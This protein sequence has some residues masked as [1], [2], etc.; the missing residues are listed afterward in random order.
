MVKDKRV[1]T[2]CYADIYKAFPD[3]GIENISGGGH[4]HIE[5]GPRGRALPPPPKIG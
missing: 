2:L 5:G 3:L 4:W 1:Y